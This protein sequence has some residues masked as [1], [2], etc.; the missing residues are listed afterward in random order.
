MEAWLFPSY[1]AKLKSGTPEL[2]DA[3][4]LILKGAVFVQLISDKKR[5][6]DH[7]EVE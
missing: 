4:L 7:N 2:V 5:I 3:S 6:P 1:T